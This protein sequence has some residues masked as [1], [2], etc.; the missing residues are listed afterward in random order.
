MN[1]IL[2]IGLFLL[3]VLVS[4]VWVAEVKAQGVF[5][6]GA[7]GGSG[8]AGARGGPGGGGPGPGDSPARHPGIVG[9]GPGDIGLFKSLAKRAEKA[10]FT[11][12]ANALN[13][14]IAEVTTEEEDEEELEEG[15]G[16]PLDIE[17]LE[18]IHELV[19][20]TINTLKS[21]Q[22]VSTGNKRKDRTKKSIVKTA[23]RLL[24]RAEK[25]LARAIEEEQEHEA[26]RSEE[27]KLREED[28]QKKQEE[29]KQQFEK[30][31]EFL[32]T[33]REEPTR[34]FPFPGKGP[35]KG[36]PGKGLEGFSPRGFGPGGSG[37]GGGATGTPQFLPPPLPA[38]EPATPPL[39]SAP[40][41]KA[42]SLFDVWLN[43][44]RRFFG[45]E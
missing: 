16:A 3:I 13:Q 21:E 15:R 19:T 9:M 26:F 38:G 25:A 8:S 10:G 4:F 5:P 27:E 11:V 44:A 31:K 29:R 1:K 34:G 30:Q 23:L 37:S 24:V 2:Y 6:P 18:E 28:F 39:P 22:S 35:Q 7:T 17:E 45:D 14:L 33:Q 41:P 12:V 36:F 40:E 32:K 20:T 43:L 42:G